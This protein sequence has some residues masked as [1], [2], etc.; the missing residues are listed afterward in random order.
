MDAA[1][2][3]D[4]DPLTDPAA[5]VWAARDYKAFLYGALKRAPA[6]VNAALAAVSDLAIRRG[7]GK[8][9]GRVAHQRGQRR[10]GVAEPGGGLG[11]RAARRGGGTPGDPPRRRLI[12]IGDQRSD[13]VVRST[14]FVGDAVGLSVT[15][16]TP[17]TLTFLSLVF[18]SY[19]IG[20]LEAPTD[21]AE[22]PIPL[23]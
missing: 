22:G 9:D 17:V 2:D 11:G 18:W 8:L 10:L 20:P 7:L 1:A 12:P 19:V 3:V 6:T 5:A 16:V 4:G 14:E 21:S 23:A 13:P 15:P